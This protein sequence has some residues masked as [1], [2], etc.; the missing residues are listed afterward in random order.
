MEKFFTDMQI[1]RLYAQNKDN[2]FVKYYRNYQKNFTTVGIYKK[3]ALA[4]E[5]QLL[6]TI[7]QNSK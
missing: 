5:K 1:H 6:E 3:D 7:F 4:E 2:L